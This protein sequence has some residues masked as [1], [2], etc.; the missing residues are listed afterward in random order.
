RASFGGATGLLLFGFATATWQVIAIRAFVGVMAGAPAAAMA[1]MAAGTPRPLL[2]RALGHF[3]AS[4]LLGLALGPV[5]A[6]GLIGA[7]GYRKTFIATAVLMYAGATVSAVLIREE[8]VVEEVLVVETGEI[9]ASDFQPDLRPPAVKPA[10]AI[11]VMLRSRVVW[12]AL[13]LVMVLSFAAPMIQPI[14]ASFVSDLEPAGR[15]TTGLVGWLFFGISVASAFSALMSGRLIRRLGLQTVLLISCIGVG[16]FLIPAGSV[17][18][19]EQLFV[20]IVLMSLFQGALQTSAVALLPSVVSSA[21]ISS[22]FG[23]YQ[24][25]QALS[26]QLGP[27]LGGA[28]AVSVG[29]SRVFPIA[30]ISLLLLGLPMLWLFKRVVA[31][32]QARADVALAGPNTVAIE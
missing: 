1:L 24:S 27:A 15:S 16:V 13:I 21:A 31:A 2:P 29:F 18:T 17:S 25:V 4:T 10:G 11:R 26:A 6:A 19:F 12:C 23:L 8:R 14:L 9:T 5:A 28:L 7:L 32:D 3:Q 30:G 22:V 20:L